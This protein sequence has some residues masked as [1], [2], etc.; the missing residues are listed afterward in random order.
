MQLIWYVEYLLDNQ[1]DFLGLLSL[2]HNVIIDKIADNAKSGIHNIIEWLPLFIHFVFVFL[3]E[4]LK[5]Q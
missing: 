2:I 5:S 3:H 4:A 1:D